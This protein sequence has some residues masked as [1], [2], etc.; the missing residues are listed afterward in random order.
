MLPGSVVEILIDGYC[1]S[2]ELIV[3]ATATADLNGV[4]AVA[5][6]ATVTVRHP[7]GSWLRRLHGTR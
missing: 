1:S 5:G 4:D 3:P 7:F 6:S 2:T